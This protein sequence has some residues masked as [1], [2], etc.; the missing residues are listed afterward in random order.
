MVGN[1]L[2]PGHVNKETPWNYEQVPDPWWGHQ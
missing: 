2:L 1:D